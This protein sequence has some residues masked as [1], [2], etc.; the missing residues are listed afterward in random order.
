[1]K[2]V[3]SKNNDGMMLT[4]GQVGQL[5]LLQDS[6][7]LLTAPASTVHSQC[8]HTSTIILSPACTNKHTDQDGALRALF[9]I[10]CI[11][12]ESGYFLHDL[13]LSQCGWGHRHS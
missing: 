9:K 5:I 13:L 3:K 12:K 1:M 7:Y 6:L 8:V 2:D 4:M 10:V 11:W